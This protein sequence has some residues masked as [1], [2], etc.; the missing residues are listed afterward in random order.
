MIIYF[1]SLVTG[2]WMHTSTFSIFFFVF[3]FADPSYKESPKF[4]LHL[5][6]HYAPKYIHSIS[7]DWASW[8]WWVHPGTTSP[9]CK[10][11]SIE[12]TVNIFLRGI[13]FGIPN[14]FCYR[15]ISV[16]DRVRFSK[17]YSSW[18]MLFFPPMGFFFNSVPF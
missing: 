9:C 8:Y 5:F 2:A 3:K 13:M 7:S 16:W 11:Y 12:Y 17:N 4:Y 10:S 6:T 15:W 14:F 18:C 1:I